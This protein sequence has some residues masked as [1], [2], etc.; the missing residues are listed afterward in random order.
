MSPRNLY[1]GAIE[2]E[3]RVK[4]ETIG[5]A[6]TASITVLQNETYVKELQQQHPDPK[7]EFFGFEESLGSTHDTM[8]KVSSGQNKGLIA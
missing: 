5:N 1:T 3:R 7:P 8:A 4:K 2:K 6:T